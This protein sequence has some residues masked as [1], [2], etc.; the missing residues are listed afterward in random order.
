MTG[1]VT[2]KHTCDVQ[3]CCMTIRHWPYGLFRKDATSTRCWFAQP[4]ASDGRK[5]REHRG[6]L[7]EKAPHRYHL[8]SFQG[9]LRTS[10]HPVPTPN[11]LVQGHHKQ[12]PGS[13]RHK[14]ESLRLAF[15][16]LVPGYCSRKHPS[17]SPG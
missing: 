11:K 7:R 12:R 4:Y 6:D 13:Q 5:V 16:P 14:S 9:E 3:R 1:G 17:P 2:R 8:V 10:F 15:C